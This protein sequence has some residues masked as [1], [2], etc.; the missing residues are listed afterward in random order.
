MQLYACPRPRHTAV[1]LPPASG[2]PA[3]PHRHHSGSRLICC[4][5]R[6]RLRC[7]PVACLRCSVGRG[8]CLVFGGGPFLLLYLPTFRPI[9]KLHRE[10]G[11]LVLACIDLQ[12]RNRHFISCCWDGWVTN[13][14][15]SNRNPVR[16]RVKKFV[17][18]AQSHPTPQKNKEYS[19]KPAR[20]IFVSRTLKLGIFIQARATLPWRHL[21][22]VESVSRISGISP[23]PTIV[24]G[25]TKTKPPFFFLK[26]CGF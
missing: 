12:F 20:S 24:T 10:A 14:F 3:A 4:M 21:T 11:G 18:V 23:T 13:H 7:C 22:T 6:A 19:T 1:D 5:L 26:V 2:G 9:S 25:P 17:L 15:S 16:E 8:F